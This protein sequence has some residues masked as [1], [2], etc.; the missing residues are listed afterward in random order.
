MYYDTVT[1]VRIWSVVYGFFPLVAL[2][3][4]RF[5]VLYFSDLYIKRPPLWSIKRIT[6]I[7]SVD[8]LLGERHYVRLYILPSF[9][10]I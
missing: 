10:I 1:C 2:K 5:S 7:V 3:F 9:L 8:L 4:S 6:Y